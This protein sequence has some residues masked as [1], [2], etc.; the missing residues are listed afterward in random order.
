MAGATVTHLP[1]AQWQQA[2][3]EPGVLAACRAI[4]ARVGLLPD[5]PVEATMALPV[6]G[7]DLDHHAVTASAAWTDQPPHRRCA[8]TCGP[9]GLD[10]A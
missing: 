9:E 8:T 5:V 7:R 6:N 10:S 2:P 3:G 1:N 4:R